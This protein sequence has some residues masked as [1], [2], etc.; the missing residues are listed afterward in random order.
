MDYEILRRV[1]CE[2]LIIAKEIKRVCDKNDIAYFLVGGTLIGAIRHKGFIPWDDDMDIGMLRSD[3]IKFVSVAPH[4]LGKGFFLQ[5]WDTDDEYGNAFAKVRMEGTLF[6]EANDAR[7][8]VHQGFWVDIFPY[9]NL[10]DD[11][12]K[13]NEFSKEIMNYR[14][15]MFMKSGL[16]VW[17][18][19]KTLTKK[20]KIWLSYTQYMIRATFTSRKALISNYESEMNRY[21]SQETEYLCQESG[22]AS[23]G[24]YPIKRSYLTELVLLPFE[25]TYFLCPKEYDAFLHSIYGDYMK[26]PPEDQRQNFHGITEIKF[27]NE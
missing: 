17:N 12:S 1:Q 6:K 26:L 3:F 20:F 4:Q 25:D 21:N 9:D 15:T 11:Q 23:F 19:E 18:R 24:K 16:T 2:M 10:P 14:Y 27:R 8:K 22:G 5:T 13:W 7:Q